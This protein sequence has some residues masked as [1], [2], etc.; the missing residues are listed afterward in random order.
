[1][2]QAGRP[3]QQE[4][5]V[6]GDGD[7]DEGSDGGSTT[8]AAGGTKL[9]IANTKEP[10]GG[11]LPEHK[12]PAPRLPR[13]AQASFIYKVTK[14]G[15]VTDIFNE[16]AVFFCLAAQGKELL[17]G[18]GNNAQLFVVEPNS[19]EKAV[20]FE[21]K[22]AS[23]ITAVTVVGDNAYIGM[24]N[25]ARLVKLGKVF[26]REGVYTSELVDAGQ[27][28]KWGKLQI[29]A[30][31]PQGFKVLMSC[32]SGNV[33]DIN[34]KSFSKWTEPKEVTG[35]VQMDCPV[36]RFA[37]YKLILRGGDGKVTP[38]V[39]EVAV[40]SAIPNL[41]PRV[42]S[43]NV[44]RMEMPGKNGVFKIGYDTKDDNGD[45]LIYKIDFRKVG[46]TGWIQIKDVVEASSFE[47]DGKTVEDGRYE[48]KVTASDERSNTPETKLTGSRVSDEVVVDNTPPSVTKYKLEKAGKKV[49]IRFTVNDELSAIG[50]VEYTVDSDANWIGIVPDDLIY[51]TTSEDFTILVE[52]LSPGQHIISLKMADAV[53]N[54]AYKTYEVNIEDK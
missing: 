40:A 19:E 41:A 35:P 17:V 32:R 27:P 49:T 37:Q 13:P 44:T 5:E 53:G 30:D 39:R 25:P 24:A 16:S 23:Q 45:K 18:T 33:K 8:H 42:E 51:D 20:V 1:M 36:N 54:T 26:A 3:E 31:V 28:A 38:V 9:Q 29:E 46:R 50:K 47:W 12:M 4:E 34:D 11:E 21:D 10:A 52:K 14:D 6:E 7:S 43:V 22:Q 48:I 15:F 2:P